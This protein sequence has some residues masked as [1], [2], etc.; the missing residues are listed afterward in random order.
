[1]PIKNVL[2]HAAGADGAAGGG[3]DGGAS[4]AGGD[5]GASGAGSAAGGDGGA[6]AAGGRAPSMD[7]TIRAALRRATGGEGAGDDGAGSGGERPAGTGTNRAP[8]GRYAPKNQQQAAAQGAEAGAVEG[9]EPQLDEN[10][11]P[12]A[13]DPNQ[14]QQVQQTPFDKVAPGYKKDSAVAKAWGNLPPD[15]RK[16]MHEREA[17]F[18]EGIKQYKGAAHFGSSIAEQLVPYAPTMKQ[19][20]IAPVDVVKT[21]G[22]TWHTLATGSPQEKAQLILQVMQDHSIDLGSLSQAATQPGAQQTQDDP[23]LAAALQRIDKLESNLTAQERQ[24]AE[25]EFNSTVQTV[26][27]FGTAVDKVGKLLR[28]HFQAVR[29]TMAQLIDSGAAKDLDEAYEQACWARKDIRDALIRDQEAERVKR[30]KA[31]AAAARTAAASNVT[32]RGAPPVAPKTGKMEDTIR[33]RY[34]Q[35]NNR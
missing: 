23:R 21:L 12:I 28:P 16:E 19:H 35:L 34:R 8:N 3:G 33:E 7:E 4:G 14:Q 20:N 11:Q 1:M 2:M 15:V 10:G 27:D 25:A 17:A 9:G 32:N 5:A 6:G 30:E 22:A 31:Q 26:N 29:E 13:Q 24:R 18:H